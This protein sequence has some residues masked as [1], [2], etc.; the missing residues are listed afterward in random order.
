M[1]IVVVVPRLVLAAIA[2]WRARA[3]QRRFP[4]DLKTPYFVTLAQ[5]AGASGPVV[6]RVFPYSF[7]VDEV[8]DKSLST[9]ATEA[10]GENTRVMLRPSCPYGED[11]GLVLG[12]E[13]V[14]DP[15]VAAN[16]ALFNL[17]ATPE[18]ENH[19]AFLDYL[20]RRYP[21]G[22]IVLVDESGLAERNAGQPG[23]DARLEER[24]ALWRQ[25]CG[26][27]HQP[28]QFVDL[29]HPARAP[30]DLGAGSRASVAQ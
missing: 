30:L 1:V 13:T 5:R 22:V 24:R 21:R 19:G 12:S 6:L 20:G 17:S 27:H 9:L 3:L 11:P 2:H 14:D 8:R 29:L 15:E 18:K 7:T 26:F 25:F 10:L 28:V 4:L 16:T 23:A